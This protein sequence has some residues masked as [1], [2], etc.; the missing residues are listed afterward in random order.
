MLPGGAK[1]LVD[2]G[3]E[4]RRG[5]H[6]RAEQRERHDAAGVDREDGAVGLPGERVDLRGDDEAR[7]IVGH[8]EAGPP[9]E[10]F[11][12]AV[13][14]V[15]GGG[16]EGPVRDAESGRCSAMKGHAF[17]EEAVRA[18]AGPGVVVPQSLVDDQGLAD[19]AGAE[20]RVVE[21]VVVRE[22]PERLHPVQDVVAAAVDG[23]LVRA[24]DPALVIAHGPS[25]AACLGI[26]TA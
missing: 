14:R 22:A 4:V 9:G 25:L 23:P 1:R 6:G 20:R 17:E 21:R 11:Q 19:L 10:P 7:V 16:H 5:G 3:A 15:F 13:A 8:D 12:Q 18:G 26:F 24:A 2:A